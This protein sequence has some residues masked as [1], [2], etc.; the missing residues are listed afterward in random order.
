MLISPIRQD[1]RKTGRTVE[2][3]WPEY[4]DYARQYGSIFSSIAGVSEHPFSHHDV[5]GQP[6]EREKGV[7]EWNEKYGR[8]Q[9]QFED[10]SDDGQGLSNSARFRARRDTEAHVPRTP[11]NI[12]ASSTPQMLS[13]PQ[14]S[15]ET[16]GRRPT[17]ASPNM[18]A[19][20]G[21]GS[22]R[23]PSRASFV[24]SFFGTGASG[25]AD[26]ADVNQHGEITQGGTKGSR[27][28]SRAPTVIPRKQ[29][30]TQ[31]DLVAS[32]ERIYLRYLL[33]GA[34][35]EIYLPYVAIRY[36]ILRS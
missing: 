8:D 15:P 33:S 32:G 17:H 10:A 6:L 19:S 29:A 36:S 12:S 1:L 3:D 26:Q 16:A 25:R 24:D 9:D 27:K 35:K 4:W 18:D 2:D 23:G 14:M 20:T 31:Q 30:I 5:S 11:V 34:E 13:S 21:K 28:V 7:A 22:I